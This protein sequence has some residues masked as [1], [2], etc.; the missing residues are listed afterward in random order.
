MKIETA[1]V[2]PPPSIGGLD[3]LGTQAPCILIYGQLLPGITNVTDRARYYS[4]Y[5]WL[6]WSYDRNFSK[7][8][9]A[10][11][12]EFFRRADCLFTLIA[13]RH[14]R[15]TD[16]DNERHGVAMVGRIQLV[17]ALDRLNEGDILRLTHYTAQD[18]QHRY[19]KNP[20]GGLGQYYAGTLSY[21]KLMDAS[22]KPWIKYTKEYGAPLAEMVDASV[23]GE[24]FWSV[25]ESDNVTFDDLDALSDFCA[26]RLSMSAE[27]CQALTD[28]Y[29]DSHRIYAEEGVERR[30]S[31]A[32]IQELVRSLPE[33]HDLSEALFRAC[34]YSGALPNAKLWTVPETLHSTLAHWSIYVRNDLFSVACQSVLSLSLREL[35]PQTSVERRT[36]HSVEEFARWFSTTPEVASVIDE[37]HV[38]SLGS[39]LERMAR[40]VPPRESWEVDGHEIQLAKEL[41]EGWN[42]RAPTGVLV[43]YVLTLIATLVMRDD[44]SQLP[45]GNLEMP[46]EALSDYPINLVSLRQRVADWRTLPVAEMFS[47]LVTWCLNTHLRVAMRKLRQTGRSTFHLRPSELGLE[48][49]GTEIPPPTHTT[50]RFWQA[51]QILRDIGALTRDLSTPNRRTMLTPEGKRLMEGACV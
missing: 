19:F 2:A 42:R 40:E 50:P 21:L 41:L 32:L 28:I 44:P 7:N 11:F 10:H 24:R 1:W 4:F 29:F 23:P 47:D 17:S 27:E 33:E 3:H 25:V 37:Y 26:C 8:D 9:P 16:R 34:T 14:A 6:I 22:A 5:P 43:G 18:S 46:P 45:Y 13:E 30:R 38:T 20:M 48:V 51:V 35:Q 49:V 39:L 15:N 31:L 12:V 36:F